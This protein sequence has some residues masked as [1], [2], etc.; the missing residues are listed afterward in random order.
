MSSNSDDDD[1]RDDEGDRDNDDDCDDDDDDEACQIL[2]TI[3]NIT[4]SLSSESA[5]PSLPLSPNPLFQI[6][7][8]KLFRGRV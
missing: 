3:I 8:C 4:Y 7:C 5:S 2:T 1:D 6:M